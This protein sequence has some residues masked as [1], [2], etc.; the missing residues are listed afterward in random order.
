MPTLQAKLLHHAGKTAGQGRDMAPVRNM[1]WKVS[2]MTR[3]EGVWA[4]TRRLWSTSDADRPTEV[5]KEARAA[6]TVTPKKIGA[7]AGFLM[8]RP[9]VTPAWRHPISD[10]VALEKICR[11]AKPSGLTNVMPRG[12]IMC[13]GE[14]EMVLR[15]VPSFRGHRPSPENLQGSYVPSIR[16]SPPAVNSM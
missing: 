16:V 2:R 15:G 12:G 7:K 6:H 14:P 3:A 9:F 13:P 5:K 4:Y 11:R 10:W 8:V 1:D